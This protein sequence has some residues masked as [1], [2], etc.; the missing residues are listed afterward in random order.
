M[1]H[2]AWNLTIQSVLLPKAGLRLSECEDAIGIRAD[3][4]RFCVADGATEAFDSRRW[5]RLLTK[6]WVAST[7]ILTHEALGVWGQALA[8]RFT[9]R[10]AK[11]SLPWYAEEKAQGGAFAAFVGLAF[12]DSTEG[13]AWQMVALGDSCLIHKRQGAIIQAT[14]LSDPAAFGFHPLLLPSKVLQQQEIIDNFIIT[15]GHAECGDVFF[16]LSDAIAAWYLQ[17]MRAT[18]SGRATHFERLV[19]VGDRDGVQ[20]VI[21][22]ERQKQ[23]LRNDDVA[24]VRVAVGDP[25]TKAG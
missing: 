10:W 13:L 1:K 18:D 6:H 20:E 23:T 5:A 2:G 16:L 8:K 22:C 21:A 11:K 7:G 14:P 3:R 17:E 12:L 24:I 19:A 4:R 9:N 25:T 15:T